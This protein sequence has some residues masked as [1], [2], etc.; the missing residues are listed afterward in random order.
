MQGSSET[1][2]HFFSNWIRG[3]F[4]EN[5][6]VE[7]EL[8]SG[9]SGERMEIGFVPQEKT[10]NLL[11]NINVFALALKAFHESVNAIE[12]RKQIQRIMTA[13]DWIEHH[14]DKHTGRRVLS[15]SS[16]IEYNH[17]KLTAICLTQ[18]NYDVVF[19]PKGM[20]RK[21]D[22][23]FDIYLI[24]DSII[25]EADLKYISSRHPDTIAKRIVGGSH[26]ARRVV[27]DVRSDIQ[28]KDLVDGLRS[29]TAKNDLL[30]EILLFYKGR[31]YRLPK[32]L[33]W[34]KKIFRIL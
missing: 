23:K 14:K 27:L 15:E 7:Q 12:R 11:V 32:A 28:S 1:K 10:P 33:I 4:A 5:N 24:R 6:F 29:G 34:S 21:D 8:P 9:D 3:R 20:F 16:V 25:L 18:V 17:E 13:G 26:Q 31:F 19:A 2:L 30:K 22:K